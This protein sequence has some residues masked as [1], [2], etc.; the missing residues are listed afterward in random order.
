MHSNLACPPHLATQW[1]AMS[2]FIEQ[3][4][5]PHMVLYGPSGSGKSTLAMRLVRAL[6]GG[7]ADSAAK[8]TLL[9]EC[10]LGKG[11]RFVREELKLFA[12]GQLSGSSSPP[13]CVVLLNGDSLTA[14]AQSALRRSIEIYSHTTRFIITATDISRLLR[15]IRSRLCE[16]HCPRPTRGA[17]SISR[18]AEYITRALTLS[19][20]E[21]SRRVALRRTIRALVALPGSCVPLSTV[22]GLY[23]KGCTGLEVIGAVD[24]AK[25]SLGPRYSTL[26]LCFQRA[27]ANFT[28][29]RLA[30]S[31]MLSVWRTGAESRELAEPWGPW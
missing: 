22:D 1:R 27:T 31:Y 25:A 5:I 18:H 7:D 9:S 28:D 29:E 23:E 12:K 26:R 8:H 10:A 19:R 15:P 20:T 30:I 14:E 13:K 21:R 24:E 3:G 2:S 6:H 17:R 11:I 16:I 4:R